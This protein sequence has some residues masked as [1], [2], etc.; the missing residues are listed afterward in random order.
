MIRINKFYWDLYKN[1][2]QG[3]ETIADFEK[4]LWTDISRV[5]VQ[6]I[7][8]HYGNG[9]VLVLEVKEISKYKLTL[10]Q[11]LNIKMGYPPFFITCAT[12][13]KE[14]LSNLKHILE[15]RVKESS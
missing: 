9:S 4:L 7:S 12:L 3:K 13:K 8:T 14:D 10:N 2:P 6:G 15:E 5:Y 1:S 11:K